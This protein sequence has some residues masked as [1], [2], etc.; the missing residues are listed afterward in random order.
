MS[1]VTPIILT[2][3]AMY[4]DNAGITV[5]NDTDNAIL[6]YYNNDGDDDS[7]TVPDSRLHTSI[8]PGD[9]D[10]IYVSGNLCVSITVFYCGIEKS[11]SV[12]VN[13]AGEGS[14]HIKTSDF[15]D[16]PSPQNS[17]EKSPIG[18]LSRI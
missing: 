15:I 4:D 10:V 11:F 18:N 1:T 13:F 5:Y 9:S 12:D 7:E 3:C 16:T 6:V 14:I 8:N 17:P 2:G